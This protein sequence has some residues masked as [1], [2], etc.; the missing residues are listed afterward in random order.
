MRRNEK[1][2]AVTVTVT[3]TLTVT[4]TL[5]FSYGKFHGKFV[6]DKLSAVNIIIVVVLISYCFT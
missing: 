3:F 4:V 5:E 6:N 1:L 2:S